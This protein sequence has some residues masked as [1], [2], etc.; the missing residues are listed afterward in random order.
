[1]SE[2]A[3][4]FWHILT[5]RARRVSPS[6][7]ES[8]GLVPGG[9]WTRNLIASKDG[10]KLYVAVGSLSNIGDAGMAAEEKGMLW[11]VV[12][13]RDGLGDETPPI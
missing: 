9:H 2:P 13:E 8:H 11:T 1:M 10:T 12:N 7:Q 4:R 6:P 5:R 3:T